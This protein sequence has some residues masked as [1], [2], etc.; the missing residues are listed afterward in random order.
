MKDTQKDKPKVKKIEVEMLSL[1]TSQEVR[2]TKGAT[3]GEGDRSDEEG[4]R[5]DEGEHE[6]GES[7]R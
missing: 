2:F 5:R 7:C 4:H 1:K 3:L 6:K